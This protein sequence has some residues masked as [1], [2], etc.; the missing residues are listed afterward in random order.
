MTL[1]AL[2]TYL[3][4]DPQIPS[5]DTYRNY[6]FETPMRVF[7]ADGALL[8][9]FGE[10]RLI[11]IKR[12]D[13]PQ[14]YVDALISTEDKRFY[15]H[16]GIDWISLTNDMLDLA[17]NPEVR[18]GAST[19]TMQIPRNIEDLSR[20]QSFLRKFKE[21]LL[22]LKI[23][24][25]L[26][27][28]EILELYV[29]VVPFGKRA[30][31]LQAAA[32]TYYGMAADELNLPQLAMLAGIPKRP[33]AGNPINGPEWAL[34]RR[35]LVLRRMLA[36][37]KIDPATYQEAIAAPITAKVHTRQVDL[38]SPYPSEIARREVV[39]KYGRSVYTGYSVYTTIRKNH[40]LAA[41][42]AVRGG[43]ESYDRRYGWRGA[44]KQ[45]GT[46]DDGSIEPYLNELA[47]TSRVGHLVP[48][49]V[50]G[51]EDERIDV[52]DRD[53]IEYAIDWDGF[54]WARKF[55]GTDQYSPPPKSAFEVVSVGDLVRIQYRDDAW[56]LSQVPEVQGA[57]VALDPNTGEVTAMVGGYDFSTGQFNHATQ[58]RR[59]P[60]SGFKPFVYS[61]AINSGRSPADIY[62]DAPLVYNDDSFEQAYRPK[63]DSGRYNGPTRMRVALYRSINLVSMRIL[64]DIGIDTVLNHA[65]NFGFDPATL[66]RNSQIAIGGGTMAVTPLDMATG[67]SVFANGGFRVEPHLVTRVVDRFGNVIFEPTYSR[68]CDECESPWQ[69]ASSDTDA[70]SIADTVDDSDVVSSGVD[71]DRAR[72]RPFIAAHRVLDQRVAFVMN[73][74]LRD[75]IQR[76]TGRRAKSLSRLDIAGKTGTTDEALDTW[77][78]G[79][80]AHLATTT[81]VGF[82][83]HRPLGA[84]E[85]GSTRP[86]TIW[87]DFMEKALDGIPE[88]TSEQP[89]GLARIRIDP[90]TGE[91]A[92]PDQED[93]VFEFFLAENV[94]EEAGEKS[95][96][97]N[98][99][100]TV[101]PE[102]I[103]SSY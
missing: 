43:L 84:N 89:K 16:S 33:E 74:L 3:Y 61:A 79:Y 7:D 82:S 81:W 87:I 38:Y 24:N 36:E 31:G 93:A 54:K 83:D 69:S 58:A 102:D 8:A 47:Q 17:F 11:P 20:K 49:V 4:L 22:A 32:Y 64:Q 25:E 94:P 97:A 63:N 52:V 27:K 34:S 28:D 30:Y 77:F 26:T 1:L 48:V 76:G 57:L 96:V 71:Q 41:Q 55:R 19:I 51:V 75:V 5:V 9:E 2:G 100:T 18:R 10:R 21:M 99:T 15:E 37:E 23:E 103:F 85:F 12:E 14:T 91:V 65:R 53:G 72:T 13:I 86:L 29:N 62:L 45:L 70:E 78:N 35:N 50:I 101:R 92:K 39:S 98:R 59:Q 95:P 80:T 44:E 73:S 42:D 68:V 90:E 66:P 46:V 56:Y 60:G 67:Y 88:S 6:S 40:Q